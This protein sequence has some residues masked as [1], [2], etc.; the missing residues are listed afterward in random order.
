MAIEKKKI[1]SKVKVSYKVH[2]ANGVKSL[3]L[4]SS[5]EEV[6]TPKDKSCA[7]VLFKEEGHS[8]IA[9]IVWNDKS[10]F[11]IIT[12]HKVDEEYDRIFMEI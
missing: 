4:G 11:E 6:F 7:F 12:Q 1:T 10:G 2:Q 5:C 8:I 9:K 3:L